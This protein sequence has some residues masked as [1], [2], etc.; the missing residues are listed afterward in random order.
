MMDNVQKVSA[1]VRAG[2]S[3]SYGSSAGYM[4]GSVSSGHG[5]VSAYGRMY[6]AGRQQ[7]LL[8]DHLE[9]PSAPQLVR[10]WSA[11]DVASVLVLFSLAFCLFLLLLLY[12]TA[13]NQPGATVFGTLLALSLVAGGVVVVERT[14]TSYK[15]RQ[16]EYAAWKAM[17]AKWE[18][19]YY[20]WRD[21]VVFIPGNSPAIPVRDMWDFLWTDE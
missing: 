19:L 14:Q 10:A 21:D 17:M 1:L 20:C 18:A 16:E 9:P 2:A 15:H 12:A 11:D 5:I 13:T 3:T 8:S 7:T 4:T 6:Q